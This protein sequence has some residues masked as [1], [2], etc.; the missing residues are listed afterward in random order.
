MKYTFTLLTLFTSFAFGQYI[1]EATLVLD[2]GKTIEAEQIIYGEKEYQFVDKEMPY[3]LQTVK[4]KKVSN[5][6]FDSI[7]FS[8]T[9]PKLKETY[10]ENDLPEGIYETIEDFYNK[11]PSSLDEIV[12][13]PEGSKLYERANDLMSFKYKSNNKTIKK[14]FAIV[15]NN[16]L[17]FG[18]LG[19]DKHESKKMKGTFALLH[20]ANRYVR[21]KYKTD[22]YYYTDMP[23][24]TLGSVIA[25][26]ALGGAVGAII[27]TSTSNGLNSFYPVVL[28]ND[29]RKFYEV[30]NCKR[31]NEYFEN[32]LS[33][34]FD[35]KKEEDYNI[36][37]VRKLMIDNTNI[38]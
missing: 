28:L 15:Y 10:F 18:I 33:L 5:L 9:V 2:D 25:G 29:E 11:T 17:Y 32:N 4:I 21:V 36:L 16:D 23:L 31:F 12:A 38:K 1:K 22:S 35:C 27:V 14:P 7:N 3:A 37:K 30:K 24:K 19:I 6:K 20:S 26:G 8:K 34:G 13:T